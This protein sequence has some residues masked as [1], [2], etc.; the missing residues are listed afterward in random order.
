M[1]VAR[2]LVVRSCA[3]RDKNYFQVVLSTCGKYVFVCD[4]KERLLEKPKKKNLMHLR[5]TKTL[6]KEENLKSNKLIRLALRSFQNSK[7]A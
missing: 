5:F 6:L 1:E 7:E 2:G 4:G 3:G